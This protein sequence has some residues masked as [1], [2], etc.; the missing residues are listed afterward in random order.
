VTG[1]A[2]EG[3]ISVTIVEDRNETRE[4]LASLIGGT[5]GFRC[6]GKYR[7][8]EEALVSF[9]A[10]PP[11]VALMDIHLPGVSG[12]EGIRRLKKRFPDTVF[13]VLSVYD[14]DDRIFEALCAG[15]SGY[16]LKKTAPLRLLD[17]L[18]DAAAGGGPLSPEVAQ[19]VIRL[20][21]EYQ[22]PEKSA[23]QLTP[24]EVRILRMISEGHDY[25]SAAAELGVATST[26]IYHMRQ[27]FSKLQVHSKSEA[28]AK[29]L[30]ARLLH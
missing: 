20:F 4:G 6:S 13:L 5:E 15:A 11:D 25:P 27:I 30:R 3:V 9:G 26:V 1:E 10:D 8:V 17:A 12:I 24:H 19:R 28:V 2:R 29:A 14:D 22:P 21:R 23:E 16:L 7:S 18:R